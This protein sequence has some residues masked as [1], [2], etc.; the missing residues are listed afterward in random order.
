MNNRILCLMVFMMTLGAARSQSIVDGNCSSGE[1]EVLTVVHAISNDG[2]LNVRS[3][4]STKGTV[5]T[6][7]YGKFHDLGGGVLRER[8]KRWSKISVGTITGWVYNKYLGYQTWYEGKG[9]PRLVADK[10][11]TILYTDN[12]VDANEKNQYASVGK[13][14]VLGDKFDENEDYYIL[15]TGHD[16]V[17]IKKEDAV[18]K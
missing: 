14:T 12:Y 5:L 10:E 6:Q 7:L 8:G 3:Q 1:P 17:F 15:T 16:Y 4:P 9:E 13:G 11:P 2:F 18:I